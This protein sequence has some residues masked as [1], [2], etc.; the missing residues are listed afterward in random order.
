MNWPNDER[1]EVC[2]TQTATHILSSRHTLVLLLNY[3]GFLLNM[4]GAGRFEQQI[5]LGT[6][7]LTIKIVNSFTCCSWFELIYQLL[8]QLL[9]WAI[10]YGS[11]N[12]F[13]ASWADQIAHHCSS[14]ASRKHIFKNVFFLPLTLW[15]YNLKSL[16]FSFNA[17]LSI[18]NHL[19]HPVQYHAVFALQ[20][21]H[22]P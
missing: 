8:N 20:V 3:N 6:R 19:L 15:E 4:F 22:F 17:R 5:F 12:P 11:L 7:L 2:T 18:Q 13:L 16:L 9:I 10:D 14:W 21:V 1:K